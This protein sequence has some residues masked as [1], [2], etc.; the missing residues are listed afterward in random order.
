[1][2][3]PTTGT[4][5]RASRSCNGAQ[6]ALTLR[7]LRQLRGLTIPAVEA[8]TGF[9]RATI[10]RVERGIEVPTPLHMLAFSDLYGVQPGD[11]QLALEYRIDEK[12]VP[13]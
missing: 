12:A 9:N 5:Q 1:M 7:Q 2:E 3:N 13:A 4:P 8:A 11:W 10:S 6:G